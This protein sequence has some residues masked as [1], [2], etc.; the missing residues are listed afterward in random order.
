MK[1]T[2][3]G[4]SRSNQGADEIDR[5]AART[6]SQELPIRT[7]SYPITPP[8]DE[9]VAEEFPPSNGINHLEES[10]INPCCKE[11]EVKNANLLIDKDTLQQELKAV[12]KQLANKV[13]T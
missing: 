12:S 7:T 13:H 4:Q 8:K 6:Q 3:Q 10:A 11:N 1:N 9:I 2:D 5:V